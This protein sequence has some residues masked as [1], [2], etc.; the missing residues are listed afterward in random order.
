MTLSAMPGCEIRDRCEALIA[1]TFG[2]ARLA[3]N[4]A[5][6]GGMAWSS[7][8]MTPQLGMLVQAGVPETSAN[9]DAATAAG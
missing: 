5:A 9:V 4:S 6:A 8:P 1:V 3:M 7:G 2:C